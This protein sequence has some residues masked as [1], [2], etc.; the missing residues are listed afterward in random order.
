MKPNLSPRHRPR[1]LVYRTS[2]GVGKRRDPGSRSVGSGLVSD[3]RDGQNGDGRGE[4]QGCRWTSVPRPG[5]D[6]SRSSLRLLPFP[7]GPRLFGVSVYAT[8]FSLALYPSLYLSGPLPPLRSL[9]VSLSFYLV[10][11]SL[12]LEISTDYFSNK[13]SV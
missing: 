1:S 10:G 8:A 9:F 13:V 12:R 6:N 4:R 11:D 5:P 2:R 7:K 3:H